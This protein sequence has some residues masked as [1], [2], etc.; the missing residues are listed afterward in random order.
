[1]DFSLLQ[2]DSRHVLLRDI[3]ALKKR[4]LYYVILVVDP[5]L[6]FSW[7]FYAIFTHNTQ[8]STIVSFFV[9]FAEVTRRGMWTLFR[10]ENEHCANVAQYKASRDVPLPYHLEPLIEP[11]SFE[12]SPDLQPQ[13]AHSL[14]GLSTGVS[15][16]IAA[17]QA[18]EQGP[19]V[20]LEEGAS[21]VRRR[22][23]ADSHVGQLSK[24]LATAHRQDFEKKRRPVE[25][26]QIADEGGVM[27]PSDDDDDDEDDNGNGS[28]TDE[29]THDVS[30]LIR[31]E[32]HEE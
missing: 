32:L 20:R 24:I 21:T 17:E 14:H 5:I 7:I 28:Q 10:V 19:D 2:P 25:D 31:E 3:V 11:D 15:P 6:R 23:R 26:A 18:G 22:R 4:W 13:V 16:Q 9:A 30:N 27:S 29:E 8:H 1:M 12:S